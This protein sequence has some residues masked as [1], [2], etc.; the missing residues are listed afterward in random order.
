MKIKNKSLIFQ[1]WQPFVSENRVVYNWFLYDLNGDVIAYI[2]SMKNRFDAFIV[3]RG[4]TTVFASL[5]SAQKNVEEYLIKRGY[6]KLDPKM[7]IL[8]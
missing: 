8:I 3:K 1:D 5:K 2:H 6:Q 4:S 7:Q